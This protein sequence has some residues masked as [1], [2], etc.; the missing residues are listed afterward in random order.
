[1]VSVRRLLVLSAVSSGLVLSGCHA[2]PRTP[3]VT[4]AAS[5]V[6]E[7][8]INSFDET[9]DYFPDKASFTK[10]TNV[11]VEYHNSYKVVTVKQPAPGAAPESYV[12]VQCGAPE[13]KLE[14]ELAAAQ[15]I[16]IPVKRVAADSTTQVPSFE[17]AQRVDAIAGVG[18]PDNISDGP[19]KDAIKSGKITGL[20]SDGM[21]VSVE[22]VAGV[23][24][25]LFVTSGFSDPA[26]A[27]IRELG[28]PVVADAEWLESTP[29]GRSE[30]IKFQAL[31]LNAES[32]INP[33]FAKIA[34]DY[35][36]VAAKVATVSTKPT[37]L[38]G[39]MYQGQFSAAGNDGYV[40]AMLR[41]AGATYV[42]AD[43]AKGTGSSKLDLEVVL[44]KS[45]NADFWINNNMAGRW[46]N[47]AEV[48][49]NE[50]RL[51]GLKAVTDGNIWNYSKR[52]NESG[53]ND[54]WQNGVVRP[55]LVL[56][57]LVA[58]FHPDLMPGHE[59]TYYEKTGK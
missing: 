53:G 10:A 18:N 42:L 29:L 5:P 32:T 2:G 27:K 9:K 39:M 26:H 33:V 49:A 3:S 15:K 57:D 16:T 7:Q 35:E 48:T 41:D 58:I 20:K 17:L 40:G 11:T 22:G 21:S 44:A 6:V 13:P 55:D 24:P 28:I 8:C 38:S 36:V 14:G 25:D 43:D 46:S 23:K 12:L 37:V 54:Y 50:P 19:T 59:F 56:A 4:T 47:L 45:T 52:I 1:M 34:T 51:A 30:W 31:F